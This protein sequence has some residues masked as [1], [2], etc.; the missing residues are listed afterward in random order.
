VTGPRRAT[1]VVVALLVLSG[2]GSPFV[3]TATAAQ[4]QVA[5]YDSVGGSPISTATD[6]QTVY[7]NANDSGTTNGTTVDVSVTNGSGGSIT[8]TLYDDGGGDDPTADDGEYWGSFTVSAT[9]T[10]DGTDTLQVAN[11]SDAS[12]SVDLDGASDGASASVTADYGPVPQSATTLDNTGNGTVDN[13]SV[14]FDEAVASGSV[15]AA[16][17]GVSDGGT[18]TAVTDN[19]D[20][21]TLVLEVDSL[22]ADDT[23]LTPDVTV[24]QDGLS[25]TDGNAGPATGDVAVTAD[26]G[27]APAIVAAE[28]AD[29]DTDG[30]VDQVTVTLSEP[31][32]NGASTL[33]ST[34]FDSVSG[35]TV[36]SAGTGTTAGDDAIVVDV[37]G[38]PTGDTSVTLS[39]L[40]LASGTLSDGTNANGGQ[41][42]G[43]VADGAA[44]TF[45]VVVTDDLDANG[46]VDVLKVTYTES[47]ATGTVEASDFSIGS[48][49]GLSGTVSGVSGDDGDGSVSITLSEGSTADTGATPTLSYAPSG[50]INVQDAAGNQMVDTTSDPA[51]DAAAPQV[52][53]AESVNVSGDGA[54]DRIDLTYS[55]DVSASSPEVGDYTLGSNDASKVT[56]D[57]AGVS[58]DTVELS[59]TAPENDTALNLTLSYDQS[60]GTHD[61]IVDSVSQPASSFADRT[62]ADGA[63]PLMESVGTQDTDSD[64][65]VDW[66]VVSFTETVDSGTIQAGD[67]SSTTGTVDSVMVPLSADSV[68]LVVDGFPTDTSVTPDVTLAGDSITDDAGT[69]NS[70]PPQTLTAADSTPPTITGATTADADDDGNID[71]IDVTLSEPIDDG[72]STLDA[73]AFSLSEGSVDGVASGTADDD[74]VELSVSGLSGTDATPDVTLAA[75]SIYDPVGN[76]IGSAQTFTG[77]T[78]GAAP[79]VETATTLDRDGDG[80]VDAA[81]LT[82]T[83]PVDDSTV[84]PGDWT[85]GS[86]T[87]DA[88]DTLATADDDTLQLRITTDADEVSGTGTAQVTYAPGTAADLSGN[89]I[90]AID[91]DDVTETDGATPVVTDLSVTTSDDEPSRIE[92]AV[93][94]SESL[95]AVEVDLSG[96]RSPTLS[97]FSVTGSG[98]YVHTLTDT[99]DREGTYTAT[100]RRAA[101][102]AGNDGA[103]GE[104]DSVEVD[105]PDGG[106]S[107]PS[108]PGT[109]RTRVASSTVPVFGGTGSVS[110]DLGSGSVGSV[111]IA[112]DAAGTGFGRATTLSSP[113]SGVPAPDDRTVGVVSIQLPD[114]WRTT[115]ATLRVTVDTSGVDPARLRLARYDEGTDSWEFFET[116]VESRTG[117]TAV[118]RAEVPGFSTF[119][120]VEA[121]ASSSTTVEVTTGT[122]TP[123]PTADAADTT[124]TPTSTPTPGTT[125]APLTPSEDGDADADA[126]TAG[127]GPGFGALAALL[128]FVALAGLAVRRRRR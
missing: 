89:A 127:D 113:P 35:A 122:P 3:G 43:T 6:G 84:A 24:F 102:A 46:F 104:A 97:S 20:D 41:T 54:A 52:I 90:A 60:A 1:V 72:A 95:D 125:D 31:L 25:D 2:F 86:T 18:V 26:D 11:G 76:A 123:T 96:P 79:V 50:G 101:D 77:T 83:G 14:T 51:V 114:D 32:D 124:P 98:P 87:V 70:N 40:V 12:V 99:V 5:I 29:T 45:S 59:V 27:A 33:D 10:D 19:D 73:S 68:N 92:V 36:G 106:G 9:S 34:T 103:A 63:G 57:S 128:A 44:P 93:T 53:S 49:N 21:A 120:V 28:T 48:A 118:L 23:A 22:P 74:A 116:T 69:P 71:R 107:A 94:A 56:L 109:A 121:R 115:P 112:S 55:E 62:V 15:D 117:S 105:I 88:V 65:T 91:A 80:D 13:V 42:V 30:T 119:A 39:D 58:G 38:T 47:V 67:F 82:F 4:D 108:A 17:F 126:T 37:S 8:V 111:E 61:S 110:F 75:D 66:L 81:T 64:G 78:G 85:L 7:I 16:D 100:L